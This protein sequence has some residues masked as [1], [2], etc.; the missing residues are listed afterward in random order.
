MRWILAG[1]AALSMGCAGMG[2]YAGIEVALAIGKA[3]ACD[4]TGKC[5]KGGHL[6]QQAA[7][8]FEGMSEEEAAHGACGDHRKCLRERN[9]GV[10]LRIE[11]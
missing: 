1:I 2:S 8:M 4:E 11:K 6:S 3:S 10:S 7:A 5:V 9:S